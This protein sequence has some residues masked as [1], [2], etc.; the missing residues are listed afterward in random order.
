MVSVRQLG[1]RQRV[2]RC[3]RQREVAAGADNAGLV[4]RA[5]AV[6][7]DRQRYDSAG[8]DQAAGQAVVAGGRTIER[9]PGIVGEAGDQQ[10]RSGA[11]DAIGDG[12][13]WRRRRG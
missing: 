8:V 10:Q 6:D 9:R 12:F 3:R 1:A 4:D 2:E 5:A 11:T 7:G 13:A